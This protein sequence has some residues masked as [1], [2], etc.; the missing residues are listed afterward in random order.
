MT[1]Q[2]N[3]IICMCDQL[4]AFEV[5]CYGNPV[6]RTPHIDQLARE[7]VRFETAVTNNPVCMPA[8][9]CLLSG[10]YSRTCTGNLGNTIELNAQGQA[11][12]PEYPSEIRTQL[13]GPTLA[14]QLKAVGYTTALIGKWHVQPAPHLVGFDQA[15]YPRVH[16]RYTGQTFVENDGAGAV[17]AGYSV[18]YEADRVA[19]YLRAP[20]EQPFFLFYNIS[21]PHMPVG[22]APAKYLTMYSPDE[23]PLRPN[24]IVDGRLAYDEHWFKIYLW[25]FLYYQEH[26]PYT[27]QLPPGFDLRHLTAL[28]YGMTTWVDDMLGRMMAELQTNGLADNTIVVFISDHGDNL[29]SHHTFN[30]ESLREES[31]RI[32][33]IFHAPHRVNPHVDQ[34]HVAQI[35]DVMPTLLDLCGAELPAT[36]QGRS[37]APLLN[38]AQ[39]TVGDRHAYIETSGGQIGVR[40]PTHLYGL[41]LGEDRQPGTST[42][43]FYDLRDDPFEMNNLAPQD[44]QAGLTAELRA[45]LLDW[46]QHTSWMKEIQ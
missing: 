39:Q 6:I 9:S 15:V 11:Y 18:E 16:H 28:Y 23:V 4:R 41:Q 13:P 31:I 24:T 10:Q 3:V 1:K 30:K 27:R 42:A 22:D 7:G 5:G 44:A 14:E 36:L 2:P 25:D 26:L 40:T 37:L 21:P 29:G 38:G 43:W 20:R 32:P 46:H 8:R 12:L 33:L 34:S 45:R 35:I 17:V 19:Q